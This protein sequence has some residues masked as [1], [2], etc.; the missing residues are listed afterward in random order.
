MPLHGKGNQV[1]RPSQV[2]TVVDN[3]METDANGWTAL[4]TCACNGNE[5]LVSKLLTLDCVVDSLTECGQTALHLA[6]YSGSLDSV[7]ALLNNGAKIDAQTSFE[8]NQPVHIAAD[9]GWKEVLIYLLE[10]G[11]KPNA[12]NLIERTPLHLVAANG[13]VDMAAF[14]LRNGANPF[15]L[16]VH[17]WNA[18]QVA[19]L[20]GHVEI[21]ELL[22]RS[23]MKEKQAV[24]KVMPRAPWHG[25]LWA[26]LLATQK[27]KRDEHEKEKRQS[28]LLALEIE[29]AGIKSKEKIVKEKKEIEEEKIVLEHWNAF[30]DGT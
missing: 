20:N 8:K 19:E 2:K 16:D 5:P 28:E 7:I 6:V 3:L 17:G 27:I 13:R 26:S 24:L 29:R 10:N 11:A 15:L 25:E 21:E 18:R 30:H 23:T 12:L 22:V 1:Y 9:R 4:H 14:L